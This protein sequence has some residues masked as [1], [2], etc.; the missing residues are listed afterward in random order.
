MSC[1]LVTSELPSQTDHGP[2]WRSILT[3]DTSLCL[4]L[5]CVPTQDL[6]H[7]L[8]SSLLAACGPLGPPRTA[9]A[10]APSPGHLSSR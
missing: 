6:G 4:R 9:F 2:K 10:F 7:H 5:A 3:L 1:A 8:Q